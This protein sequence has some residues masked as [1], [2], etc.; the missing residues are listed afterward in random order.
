MGGAMKNEGLRMIAAGGWESGRW[1]L[2]VE[3]GDHAFFLLAVEEIG[4]GNF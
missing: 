3:H 4:Q 2:D 1:G